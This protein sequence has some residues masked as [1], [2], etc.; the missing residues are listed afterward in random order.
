MERAFSLLLEKD[1]AREAAA[2]FEEL[3]SPY[4][5]DVALADAGELERPMPRGPLTERE[6]VVADLLAGGFENAEIA[7]VMRIGIETVRTHVA[8]IL[9]KLQVTSRREVAAALLKTKAR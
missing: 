6:R 7:K 9:A 5:R 2:A 4:Y 1:R 3:G 8:A